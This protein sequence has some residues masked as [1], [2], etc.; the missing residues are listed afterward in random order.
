MANEEKL[1]KIKHRKCSKAYWQK[2]IQPQKGGGRQ[3][4]RDYCIVYKEGKFSINLKP[5]RKI[6]EKI[7]DMHE[8]CLDCLP[9][10]QSN[11]GIINSF[12]SFFPI[13]IAAA[14][15]VIKATFQR[16]MLQTLF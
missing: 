4:E 10:L 6:G 3:G 9:V 16:T 14:V 15:V 5:K 7:I 13:L 11:N 2:P 12:S 1:D 8:S